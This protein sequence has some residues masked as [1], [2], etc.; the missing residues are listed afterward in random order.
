MIS[1]T[2]SGR[3]ESLDTLKQDPNIPPPPLIDPIAVYREQAKKP[4]I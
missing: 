2:V 3:I 1:P 4:L